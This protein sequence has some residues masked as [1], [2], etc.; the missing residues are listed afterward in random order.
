MATSQITVTPN[1]AI[2]IIIILVVVVLTITYFSNPAT[3]REGKA[4]VFFAALAG[5]GIFVIFFYYYTLVAVYA[6]Q[7]QMAIT[8]ETNDV[9]AQI[10]NV[11]NQNMIATAGLDPGFVCSINPLMPCPECNN[12]MTDDQNNEHD[13]TKSAS[14]VVT[15]VSKSV[16]SFNIFSVWRTTLYSNDFTNGNALPY[17][18]RYIQQANSEQLYVYWRLMRIDF[19]K[20]A[21]TFGDLLFE[22]GLPVK[23]KTSQAFVCAANKLIDDPRFSCLISNLK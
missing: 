10:I 23:T 9:N 21:Q 18:T 22:Y 8:Q 15:C 11:V 2:L 4:S 6:R 17:V 19:G 5:L 1:I 20:N 7:Q 16:L 3:F 13:N 14:D 12:Y